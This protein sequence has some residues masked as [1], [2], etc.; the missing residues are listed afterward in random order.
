MLELTLYIFSRVCIRIYFCLFNFFLGAQEF[1]TCT[2]LLKL[3][4]HFRLPILPRGIKHVDIDTN[5][6]KRYPRANATFRP[7]SS[8][9]VRSPQIPV[10]RIS[11]TYP[12]KRRSLKSPIRKLK[13]QYWIESEVEAPDHSTPHPFLFLAL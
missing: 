9:G 10:Y 2:C 1:S 13:Y 3:K 4:H 7:S 8:N 6:Q 12:S 5:R 11:E